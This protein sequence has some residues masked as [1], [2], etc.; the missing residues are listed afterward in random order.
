MLQ[1][2]IRPPFIPSL[3]GANASEFS[4]LFLKVS[5]NSTRTLPFL[6]K[7]IGKEDISINYQSMFCKF[8]HRIQRQVQK[9]YQLLILT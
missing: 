6:A 9:S 1:E 3:S 8:Q 5:L 7:K 4:S 2:P